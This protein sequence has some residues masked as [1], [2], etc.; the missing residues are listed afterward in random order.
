[1]RIKI[2]YVLSKINGERID[3]EENDVGKKRTKL[4]VVL[5]V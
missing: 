2:L 1:M 5:A 4:T 3:N